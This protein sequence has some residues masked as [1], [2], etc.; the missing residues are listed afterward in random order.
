[1]A[2]D[3]IPMT[4]EGYDKLRSDL[5]R[6]QGPQMIDVTQR[7]ATAA[8]WATSARTPSITP[9]AKT[10]GCSRPGLTS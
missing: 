6:M 5:D 4:R 7:V 2:D 8:P 3:R 1:M 9:P 10:R